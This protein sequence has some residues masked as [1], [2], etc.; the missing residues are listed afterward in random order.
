VRWFVRAVKRAATAAIA[1]VLVWLA[2][3]G[4]FTVSSLMLRPD[5]SASTDAIVVL[6]GGKL[7]LEAG[8]ELLAAGKARKLFV[9]GV[10]QQVDRDELLRGFGQLPDRVTCCVVLGHAADN[11][12]GN[13]RESAAWIREE[14][15]RSLRLVTSWY[16]MRRSLLEFERAMPGIR[17]LAHPVFAHRPDAERLWG[18]HGAILVVVEEYG[19]FLATL[20]RPIVDAVLPPPARSP[21]IRTA[22]HAFAAAERR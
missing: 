13:A 5:P 9:S 10:N 22:M 8:I 21:T 15:Y 17:I 20:V 14:G 18:W 1:A 19:K 3:L 7:R 4:W 11:T 2:G 16:H 6:T 12:F